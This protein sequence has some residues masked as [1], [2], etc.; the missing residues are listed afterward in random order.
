MLGPGGHAVQEGGGA[1]GADLTTGE[2]AM[3]EGGEA[4]AATDKA[5]RVK[6]AVGCLLLALAIVGAYVGQQ[7]YRAGE[8]EVMTPTRG[9]PGTQ[10][11]PGPTKK[12]QPPLR[13]AEGG[14]AV[15]GAAVSEKGAKVASGVRGRAVAEG[16]LQKLAAEVAQAQMVLSQSER[17]APYVGSAAPL[18][19]ESMEA[20]TGMVG[21][22]DRFSEVEQGGVKR[23]AETPVS[24]FSVDVDTASY[25][26]VRRTLSEGQWPPEGA[27][28]TE[29]MVNYFS[30]AVK[31]PG[32]GE[33]LLAVHTGLVTAPWDARRRVLHIVVKGREEARDEE[34][35]V[36]LVFLVDTSGSME[37]PDR[38][39]LVVSGLKLMVGSLREDNHVGV[40]TYAGGAEVVLEPTP[41]AEREKILRAL[42]GLK[43]GGRTS[44]HE[45][46]RTA[47]A[48][49]REAYD[50]GGVNRVVLATDGDF[51]IGMSAPGALED[52]I[53]KERESGVTLSVLGVGRGNYDDRVMQ[54]LAQAGNGTAAYIDTLME[55]KKVLSDE[56]LR[57][58]VPIAGDVKVQVE[59]NPERVAEYRLMGYETRALRRE[60][61]TNDKVD[62]GDVGSGHV[63]TALYE[64]TPEGEETRIEGLRYGDGDDGKTGKGEYPE[65]WAQVRLRWKPPGEMES[66]ESV[67]IVREREA[68]P[69][70]AQERSFAIAV[71]AFAEKLKGGRYLGDYGYEDIEALAR[72][73]R[74]EDRDGY[75]AE[76]VQLVGTARAMAQSE[77]H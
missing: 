6:W 67:H 23:V 77:G 74:G 37:G 56:V 46:I 9:T 59:F 50:A 14:R 11:Q 21:T 40:V 54:A 42:D 58:V 68:T 38:L 7:T 31:G 60:D 65:E 29:E 16:D 48:L 5:R 53:A 36:N 69:R 3:K 51:N 24:T 10:S 1:V 45:G 72:S 19:M 4:G 41:V 57:S 8:V 61:F 13:S 35:R 66:T 44:G 55:A 25:A 76:L 30:Y 34:G 2:R 18:L 73:A 33:D 28:R 64:L 75:R 12:G 62:A 32:E 63:V 71:A 52:Y 20:S 15:P 39:P 27:V 70:E 47:Y 49:A 17:S 43:A 22:G 26:Y